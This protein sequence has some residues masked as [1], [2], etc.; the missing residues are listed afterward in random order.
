MNAADEEYLKT[1]TDLKR[2]NPRE[3]AKVER[4]RNLA[5][6]KAVAERDNLVAELVLGRANALAAAS[7]SSWSSYQVSLAT[8]GVTYSTAVVQ[9]K[10]TQDLAD[11]N[12]AYDEQVSLVNRRVVDMGGA[13]GMQ[14]G[15][16]T[17]TTSNLVLQGN[18]DKLQSQAIF[19]AAVA[20]AYRSELDQMSVARSVL[21]K[22]INQANADNRTANDTAWHDYQINGNYPLYWQ[23]TTQATWEYDEALTDAHYATF[24][25]SITQVVNEY[26]HAVNAADEAHALADLEIDLNTETLK[27]GVP[28]ASFDPTEIGKV[29]EIYRVPAEVAWTQAQA[30]H[31]YAFDVAVAAAAKIRDID[32]AATFADYQGQALDPYK[33]AMQAWALA[34]STPSATLLAARAATE[35][36][37]TEADTLASLEMLQNPATGTAKADYDRALQQAA[38]QRDFAKSQAAAVGQLSADLATAA[39]D[40]AAVAIPDQTW[41]AEKAMRAYNE[42]II[43]ANRAL[44]DAESDATR[45]QRDETNPAVAEFQHTRNQ[46]NHDLADQ[47]IDY[48]QY[49]DA[50]ADAQAA[51]DAIATNAMRG[52]VSDMFVAHQAWDIMRISAQSLLADETRFSQT[53]DA[54]MAFDTAVAFAAGQGDA[55]KNYENRLTDAQAALDS[56]NALGDRTWADRVA[57]AQYTYAIQLQTN[58]NDYNNHLLVTQIAFDLSSSDAYAMAVQNWAIGEGTPHAQYLADMADIEADYQF[59]TVQFRL[60]LESKNEVAEFAKVSGVAAY[61]RDLSLALNAQA[62]NAEI[63]IVAAEKLRENRIATARD[64]QT[65][66]AERAEAGHVSK[67]ALAQIAYE[68]AVASA[69]TDYQTATSEAYNAW[70]DSYVNSVSIS[71][72]SGASGW[73]VSVGFNSS[74]ANNARAAA[75]V[76]ADSTRV[77]RVGDAALLARSR[78]VRPTWPWLMPTMIRRSG[79]RANPQ[80]PTTTS[81]RRLSIGSRVKLNRRGLRRRN[82]MRRPQSRPGPTLMPS[83]NPPS[84]MPT[85]STQRT[86]PGPAMRP[87]PS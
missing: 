3:I 26:E 86:Q 87:P 57:N 38:S 67:I 1:Y 30:D 50:L 81:C 12:S 23:R 82:M 73:S 6:A 47:A 28:N 24:T 36:D 37:K 74:Q 53:E 9:A 10:L 59:D 7:P 22:A 46:L 14:Q 25:D 72:F 61:D 56:Q 58:E 55:I 85:P 70:G 8:I 49:S 43:A 63:D 17:R 41:S 71:G 83:T 75:I 39:A 52:R 80:T 11:A 48:Q 5:L 45:T 62:Y 60:D 69:N 42:T 13:W 77:T 35:V 2:D 44:R 20:G 31:Q 54:V 51:L 18:F 78:R 79:L 65:T 15:I 68:K 34:E 21:D 76:E 84:H 33:A 19:N 16:W 27:K 66:T 64:E 29:P 32:R 40:A 4:D